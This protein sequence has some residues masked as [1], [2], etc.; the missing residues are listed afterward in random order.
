MPNIKNPELLF[1][2]CLLIAGLLI[3]HYSLFYFI[4]SDDESGPGIFPF[5]SGLLILISSAVNIWSSWRAT[6][7][8]DLNIEGR[9]DIG[10]IAIMVASLMCLVAMAESLG[11][12]LCTIIMMIVV[13]ICCADKKMRF[14]RKIWLASVLIIFGVVT[15]LFFTWF[16][17][18]PLPK[19]ILAFP[20]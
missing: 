8:E 15:H 10:L 4:L 13:G 3:L 11:L 12:F 9:S 19:G 1:S 17:N 16:L 7:S 18:V 5:I 2:F 6:S 14:Y 20:V